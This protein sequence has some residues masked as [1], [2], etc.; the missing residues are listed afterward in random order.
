MVG[1]SCIRSDYSG[2]LLTVLRNLMQPRKLILDCDPGHDD[3]VA[4]LSPL[5]HRQRSNCWVLLALP[6]STVVADKSNA[7]KICEL[8]GH[9]DFGCMPVQTGRWCD[10]R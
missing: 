4:I 8:P 2:V 6:A 1:Y 3:A 7:L 5:L 9:S 10:P